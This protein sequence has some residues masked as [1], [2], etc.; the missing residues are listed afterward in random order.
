MGLGHKS[1][2]T[3]MRQKGHIV[4]GDHT[5]TSAKWREIEQSLIRVNIDV[6]FCSQLSCTSGWEGGDRDEAIGC[7]VDGHSNMPVPLWSML[8]HAWIHCSTSVTPISVINGLEAMSSKASV[9][10]KRVM[11]KSQHKEGTMAH[12]SRMDENTT[13]V[14][15]EW[16]DGLN[17]EDA[18]VL[19]VKYSI[20]S[21]LWAN[22][23][24]M[25]EQ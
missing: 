11:R 24:S 7:M 23:H 2:M 9:I 25:G 22:R 6:I 14:I 1:K 18:F 5:S 13:L 12:K 4:D 16:W 10:V 15:Q 8:D 20:E 3:Q 21:N 19:Q 17:T